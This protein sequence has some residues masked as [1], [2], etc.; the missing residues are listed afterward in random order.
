LKTLSLFIVILLLTASI[1]LA[2]DSTPTPNPEREIFYVLDYADDLFE[3]ELWRM[4]SASEEAGDTY[5]TWRLREL[6]D[7][8]FFFVYFHFDGGATEAA[9][10]DYFDD[11]G[12]E[13]LL[14]NYT[15]YEKTSECRLG[16]LRLYEFVSE[17]ETVKRVMRYWVLRESD[18]RVMG[19]NAIVQTTQIALLNEYSARV[20]PDL[21]SCEAVSES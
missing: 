17:R 11:E 5:V 6:D 12:F 4:A 9:I 18:T 15:P 7:T 1:T 8:L 14:V 3:P 10:D 21:P 2:Q 16:N 19:V 13:A 20:F